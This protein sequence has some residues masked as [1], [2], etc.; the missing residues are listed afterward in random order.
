MSKISIRYR[1]VYRKLSNYYDTLSFRK[2]GIKF[3]DL[4]R[5]NATWMTLGNVVFDIEPTRENCFDFSM[6]VLC[7]ARSGNGCARFRYRPNLSKILAF[8]KPKKI[9]IAVVIFH[10]LDRKIKISP[11]G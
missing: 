3:K 4:P 10:G 6:V 8:F 2:L 5:I 7:G 11:P 9:R 1:I